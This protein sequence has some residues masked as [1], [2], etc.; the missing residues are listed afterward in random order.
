VVTNKGDNMKK[1]RKKYIFINMILFIIVSLIIMF[2]S[3]LDLQE[4]LLGIIIMFLGNIICLLLF[5]PVNYFWYKTLKHERYVLINIFWIIGSIISFAGVIL[6]NIHSIVKD[7]EIELLLF[8]T[9][10][11][12]IL[13]LNIYIK[14]NILNKDN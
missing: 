6:I 12:T 1:N 9:P 5:M 8:I 3:K 10:L 11:I 14:N 4:R 2:F 13:L 7:N